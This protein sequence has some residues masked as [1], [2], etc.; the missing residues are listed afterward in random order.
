MRDF[1]KC[2]LSAV[3]NLGGFA[4]GLVRAAIG[5]CIGVASDGA[6][7]SCYFRDVICFL[8]HGMFGGGTLVFIHGP[9]VLY[10]VGPEVRPSSANHGFVSLFVSAIDFE[11]I[12][13]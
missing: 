6:E 1:I 9:R 4:Y 2:M 8:R 7:L 13:E 5:L 10:I 11:M 3:Q 12:D